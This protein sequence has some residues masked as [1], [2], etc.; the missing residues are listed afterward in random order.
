MLKEKDRVV[1][2]TRMNRVQDRKQMQ[3]NRLCEE[4]KHNKICSRFSEEQ[5]AEGRE[6]HAKKWVG[7]G[8]DHEDGHPGKRVVDD[9]VGVAERDGDGETSASSDHI[10]SN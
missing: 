7:H 8:D 4:K 9:D 3:N 2:I 10:G 5:E 6:G 1:Y